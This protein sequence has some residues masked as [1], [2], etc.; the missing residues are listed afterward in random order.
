MGR[1]G[2]FTQERMQRSY[3]KRAN[4]TGLKLYVSVGY[5]EAI[6]EMEKALKTME[7]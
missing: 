6:K 1:H 7:E 5:N 3:T 4:N 2:D